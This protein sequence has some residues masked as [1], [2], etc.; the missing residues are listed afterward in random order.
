MKINY[1]TKVYLL[2]L[3]FILITFIPIAQAEEWVMT[4]AQSYD[5][6]L[7]AAERGIR[8]PYK[9]GQVWARIEIGL[10]GIN[11]VTAF[12]KADDDY[13]LAGSPKMPIFMQHRRGDEEID[14]KNES[15]RLSQLK[16][17]M[18]QM[19]NIGTNK[20]RVCGRLK[21]A[22]NNIHYIID[23]KEL[24]CSDWEKVS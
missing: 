6:A 8:P 3:L 20:W 19:Q 11:I 24:I 14:Q 2:C 4:C 1:K 18:W 15:I 22:P 12:G 13:A 5:I 9:N 16:R 10:M 7:P 17:G 21:H 23:E